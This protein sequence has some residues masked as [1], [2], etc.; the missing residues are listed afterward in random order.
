MTYSVF[1]MRR[2]KIKSLQINAR[3]NVLKVVYEE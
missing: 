1:G 2:L 3:K